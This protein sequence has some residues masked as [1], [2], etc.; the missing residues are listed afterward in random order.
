[1]VVLLALIN[2]IDRGAMSYAAA[3]ITGEY[4]LDR[5]DWGAVLGYFGYGYMVGALFG[6][7]LADRFGPRKVWIVAGVTWS[8]FEIATAWAGDFGLAFLGGSALAGFATIRILFGAAEGPAYSI[9]NKTIANWATP[10]ERGFVVGFG[11][12]STPLGALLTAPVAVGLLSLTGSWRAMFYILGAAGLIVLVLFMRIFTD[13]PDTNPRVS[14]AE[15]REIQAARAEQAAAQGDAPALPWWSFFRSKTLLLNTLGYFSFNYVNFLLLTWTP[16]YLQ[17]TFGYSLSSLWYM[18]M[19][20][21]TGACVT[22]LL[23]GR[24]SDMLAKRTGNLK[25]ARS[26][27][28]AGCLLATTLCFLMVSQ[29]QSVFAVIALMTLA[30][31]LNA[32]PN[33]VYWAVVIDTAPA[34]RVGT[35]SGLMHFFANI[36]SILAP[37]LT[38]YLAVRHGYSVMFVAASV[39]TAV[40]MIAMLQVRPGVGPRLPASR[41][42]AVQ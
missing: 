21:W 17:D 32:M 4:G 1:M 38:G 39:A 35:F 25:I 26:W 15:L 28:A 7:M 11:L 14:P 18:G 23:G 36:A 40:G 2:Y 30:N 42:G 33:S 34:S 13:R 3:H 29:A 8:I 31:A 10:R 5:G 6:G 37:T 19:I 27:F 9:I 41:Q 16:K 22:V 12:L 20:P 24:I